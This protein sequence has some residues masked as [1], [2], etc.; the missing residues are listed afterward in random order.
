M[1]A[2]TGFLKA[3]KNE[4][5]NMRLSTVDRL[6]L[7]SLAEYYGCSLGSAIRR[8]VHERHVDLVEDGKIKMPKPSKRK[9]SK[10]Q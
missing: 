6:T 3:T 8:L 1:T 2:R 9:P 10:K 7:D 4:S 5:F